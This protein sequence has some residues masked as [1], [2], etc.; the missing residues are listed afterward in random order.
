[1]HIKLLEFFNLYLLPYLFLLWQ[2]Q[3]R[4]SSHS[5]FD[6]RS[7]W[8]WWLSFVVWGWIHTI[9]QPTWTLHTYQV[10]SWDN[11]SHGENV[12]LKLFLYVCLQLTWKY[13]NI[14]VCWL[15]I[16]HT[17]QN[18]CFLTCHVTEDRCIGLIRLT[19]DK[20]NDGGGT[21]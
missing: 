7:I 10:R 11:W 8:S 6:L 5:L 12:D 9:Y 19:F 16:T 1:M 13:Y 17:Y 18:E 20:C 3:F 15:Q 14:H 21:T 2:Y 4:E